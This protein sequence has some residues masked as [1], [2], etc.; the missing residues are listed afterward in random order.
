MWKR[1]K[2]N[3]NNNKNIQIQCVDWTNSNQ[4]IVRENDS[5][6]E[7]SENEEEPES[8]K[9]L[10]EYDIKLFGINEKGQSICVNI[11]KFTP[12]YFLEIP[13]NISWKK[14][15]TKYFESYILKQISDSNYASMT[16]DLLSVGIVYR[17]KMYNFTNFKKFRFIKLVFRNSVIS[18]FCEKLF[19]RPIK[20]DCFKKKI[21]FIPYETN[22]EPLLRFFHV[23]DI[24]PAGWIEIESGKYEVIKEDKVSRCQIEITTDWKNI[25]NFKNDNI[26]KITQASFD[27][28]CDSSHGDFPVPIKDYSKLTKDILDL[29]RKIKFK[30]LEE[31]ENFINLSLKQAFELEEID[32]YNIKYNI[33]NIF[34]KKSKKPDIQ[35]I[36]KVSKT[37]ISVFTKFKTKD[38]HLENIT[39][40]LN[41]NFPSV[42]G[43][44]VIQIGITIQKYGDLDCYHRHIITLGGCDKINNSTV[45]AYKNEKDVL[46]S[47][48]K[49]IQTLDPDI[50]TGYNIFGFDWKYLYDRAI[51]LKIINKFCNLGRLIDKPSEYTEKTLASSALGDNILK[52]V[53]TLGRVQFDLM[54][55]V[56][57]D[58]KLDSY[59]L[60][61]VAEDFINDKVLEISKNKITVNGHITL[62]ENNFITLYVNGDKYNNGEKFKIIKMENNVLT[63]NKN[64]DNLILKGGV[65]WRL[66]KDDVGPQ[67]IFRLQKGSDADRA[68]VAAYCIQDCA[69][70]NK[71]VTKLC[72]LTNNLAMS[73]VCSVPLSY[74]FMRGQGIKIFSL[75]AK[76]C[77]KESMLIPVVRKDDNA[78]DEGYEGAIVLD[79]MPG[80][81]DNDPITVMDYNSLYPSSMIERNISHDSIV[82]DKKYDNLPGIEYIDVTYDSFKWVQDG[83]K[84][85]K[86]KIKCGVETCRFAQ[87]P[88]GKKGILPRILQFLLKTRKDTK[89]LMKNETDPFKK[90]VYDGQQLAYK[91]TANSLY[92]QT[93]A[94]TSAICNKKIAASTTATG[95]DR[96]VFAKD[97]V[98]KN[99]DCEVVYGDTD[100]IFVKFEVK[101]EEGNILKGKDAI[102]GSIKLGDE[103]GKRISKCLGAPQ[104]LEYEKVLWPLVLITKKR[105]VG[106]LYEDDPN[107]FYMKCMGIV[108]KRRDNAP[109]VKYIYGGIIDLI[110][111]E[112][113]IDKA[114][115]FFVKSVK[116]MLEGKFDLEMFIV[117]KTLKGYYKNPEQIAHKVLADRIAERDPGNKP[118]SNER[119]RYAYIVNPKAKL[120]GEKIE[121]PEYIIHNKLK[122]GYLHYLTNQI[123]VPVL[124]IFE[125]AMDDPEELIS[126]IIKEEK[127]KQAGLRSIREFFKPK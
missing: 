41:D 83:N 36:E 96:L 13:E 38:E 66:A 42:E 57:R 21:K 51:E 11:E 22:I 106:N 31:K 122:L 71:L 89:K 63:L 65:K 60:D 110:L 82:I 119:I 85:A 127:N 5:E 43:D 72:I 49:F 117:S 108:L 94:S 124:Q 61:F 4:K 8:E 77:R 48:V 24:N 88:D 92:G 76:F 10:L 95:R 6:F 78:S 69:L 26:G 104:N 14:T 34:T 79:P 64:I 80:I 55:V 40:I 73:N 3:I 2:V 111:N 121:T 97:F 99:Y 70:V 19:Y 50:I 56:Q 30:D 107:K 67:D 114:A 59:K 109:I 100:S 116:E 1:N 9:K 126:D 84:K 15:H 68:T 32:E 113:N 115:R 93:G 23:R 125:L 87:F 98:L 105:Y 29:Y 112:Q 12:Y 58:H 103:A 52:Y 54:K 74:I 123:M 75:V 90:E 120:Q 53:S 39:T 18:R 45:E 62:T 20:L 102:P 27:I 46:L 17:Q 25:N 86:K 47:F 81:Y 7:D 44:K 16:K 28:E 118:Q 33:N 101:D 35:Q 91:V 37:I